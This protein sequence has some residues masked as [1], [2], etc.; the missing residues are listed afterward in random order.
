MLCAPVPWRVTPE[1]WDSGA[2]EGRQNVA[3]DLLLLEHTSGRPVTDRSLAAYTAQ[4]LQQSQ[5][6]SGSEWRESIKQSLNYLLLRKKG[7]EVPGRSEF[8]S[9]DVA[10]ML[11][12][13][14]AEIQPLFNVPELV[15]VS[16]EGPGDEQQAEQETAALNWYWRERLRGF[17]FLD[18][19]LQ[20]ALLSRN[21]FLKVW[22]EESFG[23]PYE[24]EIEGT[25]LEIDATIAQL[26]EENR[27][28][29]LD[30]EMELI[31][32]AIR[33]RDHD[34]SRIGRAA[35]CLSND[36]VR[37]AGDQ[38][39][40]G[41]LPGPGGHVYIEGREL[42]QYAAPAICGGAPAHGAYGHQGSWPRSDSGR[43]HSIRVHLR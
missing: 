33:W 36:S 13:V 8:Q 5:N 37:H 23:L 30:D 40:K 11:D 15:K 19:A 4:E 21:G 20:D 17:E 9:G 31:Q 6:W 14:Q 34:R 22:Y 24:Q 2:Y 7:D 35:G 28:D 41:R 27:V 39:G 3:E 1:R 18:E 38:G 12:H 26:S 25:E 16:E 10:D 42:H 43:S 29:P 32:D